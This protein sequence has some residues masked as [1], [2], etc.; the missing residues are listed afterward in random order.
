MVKLSTL[1]SLL[2]L[3]FGREDGNDV[4]L[5]NAGLSASQP[6]DIITAS[7]PH[8]EETGSVLQLLFECAYDV[9]V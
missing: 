4:F 9:A 6:S 2:G 1:G 5:R 8:S 7:S 3:L